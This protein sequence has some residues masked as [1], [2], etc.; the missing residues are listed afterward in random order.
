MFKNL[1]ILKSLT[2][3]YAED[4]L[5]IQDSISR[6][7]KMF[8]KDVVI[9]NDGKEAIENYNNKK[10]DILILD[11]VMPN[12]NGYE[13][14]KIVR[15]KDKKIPI[16]ITS[17]YTDKEKLLNAIELNLIKYI[18][19]PILYD[20]L[21]KVFENII[22][23]ME[24]NNLLQIK[25]DEN[26]YYSFVDKNIIKNGEKITLTKNEVLFLE[27]LLEKPNHLISKNIIENSVFKAS[28]DENTLRNMVY[29]LRKKID[30][31]TIATIKDLGYI[32]KI[33]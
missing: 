5:V 7:L 4:D 25:L 3:L 24:E 21:I 9:A 16:L 6:I 11:Y 12:L 18:E 1:T 33:K 22:K 26:I 14:A 27:L 32:I 29:R 15:E 30:T 13:T 10:I 17:A 28:V 2:V 19:K 31:D 23:Y 20:D 8:F